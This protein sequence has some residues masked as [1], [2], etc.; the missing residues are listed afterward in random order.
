[1]SWPIKVTFRPNPDKEVTK[2]IKVD[3]HSSVLSLLLKSGEI[4]DI[5]DIYNYAIS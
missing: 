1:M 5:K 3:P 4:Y 2:E